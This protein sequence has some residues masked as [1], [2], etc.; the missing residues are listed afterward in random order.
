[1]PGGAS[2][3]TEDGWQSGIIH[4]VLIGCCTIQYSVQFYPNTDNILHD[5]A[6]C[7]LMQE[8][9]TQATWFCNRV[10]YLKTRVSHSKSMAQWTWISQTL[11]WYIRLCT[12]KVKLIYMILYM[13]T[14]IS[15]NLNY[16][17]I[18]SLKL[19]IIKSLHVQFNTYTI[20]ISM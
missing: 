5:V 20:H 14:C 4:A 6:I 8:C 16:I 9:S 1:M 12:R 19:L 11:S 7:G 15:V 13:Y 3:N 2:S 18:C 17:H 10:L